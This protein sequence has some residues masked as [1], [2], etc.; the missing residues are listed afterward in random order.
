MHPLVV[1]SGSSHPELADLVA[2]SLGIGVSRTLLSK[3]ANGETRV[4][5]MDSVRNAD[6]Y[7]IQTSTEPVN[8]MLMELMIMVQAC[9]YAAVHKIT[10]VMPLFFYSRQ[11]RLDSGDQP[12]TAKLVANMLEMAGVNQVISLQLHAPQIQGFFDIPCANLSMD[13]IF[14][15][16]IAKN[17]PNYQDMVIVTPDL[18]EIRLAADIGR[19]LGNQVA[20]FR[21]HRRTAGEISDMVLVGDVRGK[22]AVIV[23]DMVDTGGTLCHAAQQLKRNGALRIYAIV[24]HGIFSGNAIEKFSDSLF[25]LVVCTNTVPQSS[26][27]TTNPKFRVI[28]I[29]DMI[30]QFILKIKA[31]PDTVNQKHTQYC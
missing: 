12:I 30:S 14:A 18:G 4:H 3:F 28:N 8:D 31:N 9:R 17:I 22:S 16:W 2:Q 1:L 29:A 26:D 23:D 6:V 5:L 7:I 19:V 20:M 27:L 13:G 24:T 25:D 15:A 21:K 11:D 10:V